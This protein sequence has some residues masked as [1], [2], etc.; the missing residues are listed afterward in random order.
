MKDG[1]EIERKMENR[2]RKE[3]GVKQ[4]ERWSRDRMKDGVEIERIME[5]R[6]TERW[7]RDRKNF[8]VQIERKMEQR[9]RE[10]WGRYR[11]KDE[12]EI[13]RKMEQRQKRRWRRYDPFL[14]THNPDQD[15]FLNSCMSTEQCHIYLHDFKPSLVPL[16]YMCLYI[17]EYV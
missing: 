7:S 15:L 12:V 2:D 16:I 9:Y 6:Q 14:P 10:R 1:V 13:V 8:R 17:F 5:Q 4:K 3:E 11:M